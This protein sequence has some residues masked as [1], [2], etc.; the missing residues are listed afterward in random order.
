MCA[1]YPVERKNALMK[2]KTYIVLWAL[3]AAVYACNLGLDVMEVDAAQYA[4]ISAEMADNQSYLEV[5]HRGSDYLDKPPLLFWMASAS[6]QIL[7]VNNIA[8]KLPALLVI[9][10]GLWSLY[11]LARLF[12]TRETALMAVTILA[13]TQA[14]FLMTNDVRTDGLLTGFV[15]FSVYTCLAYLRDRKWHYLILAGLGVGLAMLS[16]GPIGAAIPAI[17]LAAHLA[18]KRQ[19]RDLF[20]PRWVVPVVVALALLAP[21]CYGLYQ[22]F[23]LHPEKEVYGLQGPSGL[24]FF[25]WT[26]SFGRITGDIYWDN[27]TPFH[28]FLTSFLWD[29]MPW[30]L[31]FFTGLA[32]ALKQMIRQ[33]KS[34]VEFLST[35]GIA[36]VFVLLS[37]SRYKLP[38]YIFPLFPFAALLTARYLNT[39]NLKSLRILGIVQFVLMHAF[40]AIMTFA[41]LYA[42]DPHY[43]IIPAMTITG[44]IAMWV[45]FFRV[46]VPA[47]RLFLISVVTAITFSAFMAFY[48]YP[49]LMEYQS[50]ALA[51]RMI[52]QEVLNSDRPYFAFRHPTYTLD[53]YSGH[54]APLVDLDALED[55]PIGAWIYLTLEEFDEVQKH[56]LDQFA[57]VREFDHYHISMLKLGFVMK[58]SRDQHVRKR[59]LIERVVR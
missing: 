31:V 56:A 4:A 1:R 23:D 47:V 5:C 21:M 57:I 3:I 15:V 40:F 58:R 20:N 36:I 16:K 17:V 13:S 59:Y 26:Q 6:F 11:K 46:Q 38:H 12:D 39:A 19:W 14:F 49:N 48:L 45:C 51:G 29:F 2:L 24:K 43:W 34:Y 55:I 8:Y 52:H 53:F 22:Q 33:G 50:G 44:F 41:Y 18:L 35:A 32:F 54:F 42:F 30:V 10:L 7:G 27:N 28:F 9:L 37:M 25:F